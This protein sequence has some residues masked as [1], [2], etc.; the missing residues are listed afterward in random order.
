MI[1]IRFEY[2]TDPGYRSALPLAMDRPNV[3]V[4]RTFS[5]IYGLAGLRLGYALAHPETAARIDA[6]AADSNL[7]IM[8]LVA[9]RASLGDEVHL[10]TAHRED[11]RLAVRVEQEDEVVVLHALV[12]LGPSGCGKT[13]LL[14]AIAGLGMADEGRICIGGHDVTYLPPRERN[15]SMVFQSYAI[16]PHM[17]VFDNIAFGLKMRKVDS[18]EILRR[19]QRSAPPARCTRPTAWRPWCCRSR[20][21]RSG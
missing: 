1:Q 18:N 14:R 13:T 11:E 2:V 12:L 17:T 10:V 19:V 9:A 4:V 21:S 16:F 6:Y 3:V 7:N 20:R 15:I 8:G 5:K